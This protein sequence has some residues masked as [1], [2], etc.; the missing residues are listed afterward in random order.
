MGRVHCTAGIARQSIERRSLAMDLA[1]RRQLLRRL[2][3]VLMAAGM[4]AVDPANA[5]REFPEEALTAM[6]EES[7]E[8]HWR[9]HHRAQLLWLL[10]RD[11]RS[12]VRGRVAEAAA[13]L[14]PEQAREALD[15]L[16]ALVR[17]A[18]RQVRSLAV[19]GLAELLERALPIDRTQIVSDWALSENA[20][21]RAAIAIVL[22][23]R[24]LLYLADLALAQLATD[25]DPGVR[26]LA[27]LAARQRWRED[28]ASYRQL[29]LERCDDPD[30]R[31]R[32][33]AR[34]L[35]WRI[36]AAATSHWV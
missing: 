34:K 4:G 27:L 6:V 7:L 20:R 19:R 14:W 22:K 12:Q 24:T 26:R 10:A 21:E 33:S 11:S 5:L 30:A 25:A 32:R 28:S 15:L 9:S 36:G 23:G 29:A 3:V 1:P 2:A 35:M 31:V 16:H 8:P 18:D 13:A 17:D